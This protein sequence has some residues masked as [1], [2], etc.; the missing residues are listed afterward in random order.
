MR[1]FVND[2][3][4]D[5]DRVIDRAIVNENKFYVVGHALI[6]E[7]SCEAFDIFFHSI[8]GD[9]YRYISF[10]HKSLFYVERMQ[11]VF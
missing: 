9:N 11:Y 10:Y 2:L 8:Y 7:R 3:F 4:K 1:V 5:R 6:K